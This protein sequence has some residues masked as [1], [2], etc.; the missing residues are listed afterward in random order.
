MG[1]IIDEITATIES[2]AMSSE[3]WSED[4]WIEALTALREAYVAAG[5]D[6]SEIDYAMASCRNAGAR[7]CAEEAGP[8]VE[9]N[10]DVRSLMLGIVDAARALARDVASS[11]DGH[12]EVD[13]PHQ[14]LYACPWYD[15]LYQNIRIFA[16]RISGGMIS[17][18]QL[19]SPDEDWVWDEAQG[20]WVPSPTASE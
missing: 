14:L 2:P 19:H 6:P 12:P 10:D 9:M 1:V 18:A 5:V 20:I 13:D 17:E 16:D 4:D 8:I 11:V 3:H 15:V 7:V